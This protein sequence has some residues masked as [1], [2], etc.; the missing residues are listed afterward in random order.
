MRRATNE[1]ERSRSG[2]AR[3][4]DSITSEELSDSMQVPSYP[5][6][7]G[8]RALWSLYKM[9][10]ESVAYNLSAAAAV[11]SDTNVD[12]LRRAF[13]QLAQRHPMLRTLFIAPTAAPDSEPR[14]RILPTAEVDF[15]CEDA[16][17]LSQAQLNERLA[18]AIYHPFDLEHRPGWRVL[19]LQ[20]APQGGDAAAS[21]S[22]HEHL[23]LLVI[24]HVLGD[25]WSIAVI[26]SEVGALYR[27]EAMGI[28]ADLKPLHTSYTDHICKE[29]EMLR[30]PQADA[31][32]EYWRTHLS[33]DLPPIDLPTDRPRPS[34]PT[35]RG[36]AQSIKIGYDLAARLRQLAETGHVALY[37]V[38]LTAFQTLLHRYTG[39]NDVLVGFPKAGRTHAFARVV[40]YFVNPVVTRAD[41]SENPR[42]GELLHANQRAIEDGAAHDWYPFS[43]L[44]QRLRPSREFG[45][46]PIFQAMFSWQKTTALLP[47]EQAGSLVRE[48]GDDAVDLGGL[49][50]RPVPLAHH[51]APVD[52]T[53][54]AIED[55]HGLVA[56]LEYSTDLFDA[57]TI[58]RMAQ[59]FCLLLEGIA[60]DPERGVS[61][62]PIMPEYERQKLVEEWNATA[63]P[64]PTDAC[65]HEL[66]EGQAERTPDTL[67]LIAGEERLT[68]RALNERANQLAHYLRQLG[69]VPDTP[70]GLFCPRSAPA[71]IGVLAVL[72][73]GGA[74][75]PLDPT[76]PDERLA[77]MLRDA[78]VPLLLTQ[79]AMRARLARIHE[80][81]VGG[82]ALS[83]REGM[84]V[85]CLDPDTDPDRGT[86]RG[87]D[88]SDNT[89]ARRISQQ[90]TCNPP[91]VTSPD[92]LA[93]IIYTSGS[94]GQPNGVALAH[95]GVVSLLTDFQRRQSLLPGDGCSWWTS[96]S[97][98]V[99]VYEIF[100]SWLTG[101]T[102]HVI[103]E[104]IRLD[105]PR[106][107]AWL[108]TYQIRSAY[109]PPFLLAEFAR[110]L[111]AHPGASALRRLLVGVEPI[112]EHLLVN[113][114]AQ[115]PDLCLLNG[116]GPSETTIC[117]TLYQV[118]A[119]AP[120]GAIAHQQTPIGGPAANTQIYLLDRHMQP[121]PQGVVGEVYIGGVGLARGY[122]RRPEL[123]A[124]RFLPHPFN[125]ESG[126]RLY[127]TGDLARLLPDGNLEFVGR[128][129]TQVKLRGYRIELGEIEAALAQH[130]NVKQ[131]AVALRQELS[132]NK[133]LVAYLAPIHDPP[134]SPTELRNFLVKSLPHAVMPSAFVVL[135]AFPLTPSGK[136]DRRALP[137]PPAPRRSHPLLEPQPHQESK[138]EAPRTNA[139]RTLVAIWQQV[140]DVAQ[141]G[142]HDNF[143]ELGGDSILGI[144]IIARAADAGLHVTPQQLFE[145]P[146][147]AELAALAEAHTP[148]TKRIQP[149]QG[150]LEGDVPLTPIQ[151]WFFERDHPNPHHWNQALMFVTHQPLEPAALRAAVAAIIEHHDALRLRYTRTLATWS[152]TYTSPSEDDLCAVIDLSSVPESR[153]TAAIEEH[154]AAL[155]RGLNLSTGP[156]LRVAYF[157]LGAS[158][159]G[160]L[161][162]I[163]H[164]LTIDGVSWRILI[165]DFQRAYGQLRLGQP[166]R[167]PPKTTSYRDWAQRLTAF[168]QSSDI[169]DEA[170]FWLNAAGPGLPG[171]P[172]NR[173]SATGA[174][175][176]MNTEASARHVS[177]C[178]SQKETQA[179]LQR[180]PI[181]YGAAI[182]D[183]LL[184]ALALAF[185]R[186]TGVPALWIDLEGHGREDIFDGIDL[187]RTVGW[188]TTLYPVRLEV[189][190]DADHGQAVQMIKEQ[191]RRIPYHGLAYGLLRYLCTDVALRQQ[192]T[193]IPPPQISF[194]YLGQI[195]Q[196]TGDVLID[197]PA[198]ESPGPLRSPD[199]LRSH[200]LEIDAAITQGKLRLDWTY[201]AHAH[202]RHTI[203]QVAANFMEGMRALIARCD[204]REATRTST[205]AFAGDT[206]SAFSSAIA[207]HQDERDALL[208]AVAG[209]SREDITQ[210]DQVLSLFEDVA[211]EIGELDDIADIYP[212]SPMQQGMI[213]HTML[214]PASGIYLEQIAGDIQGALNVPA[215][216]R[217]WQRV[218]ERHSV[219]RTAI[220]GKRLDRMLQVV[221]KDAR[222]PLELLDWRTLA[223]A[224]QDTRLRALLASDRH[225][226]FDL[227]KAPLMRLF[228]VRTADDMHRFVLTYHHVVLD[229]WSL[230]LLFKEIFAHYEAIT[231]HEELTL[232]SARP[233]R[234]YIAWLQ[235]QDT[236]AAEAFW[237]NALAGCAATSVP[238]LRPLLPLGRRSSS[239]AV[240]S[241]PAEHAMSLPA[242]ATAALQAIAR[243]HHLTLNTIVQ[244]ALALLLSRYAQQ[245]E[246]L[247]GVTVAGRSPGLA[248]IDRMIGLFIN[249]LPLRVVVDPHADLIEWLQ[250]LQQQAIK[251]QQYDYSSLV[252]VQEWSG[253]PRGT[254]LFETILVF[255]N[256]PIEAVLGEQSGSL[257]IRD[258]RAIEHVNYPLAVVAIPGEQLQFK[259]V[260]DA[261]R[262]EPDFINR[263]LRGLCQVLEDMATD[264]GQRL[265]AVSIGNMEFHGQSESQVTLG[266]YRIELGEVEAALAQ[267]PNV[268]QVAVVARHE[269]PS[270]RGTPSGG[271]QSLVAY[272]I[273]FGDPPSV[274]ELRSFLRDRLP[275]PMIPGSFVML[276]VFPLLPSGQVDRPTLMARAEAELEPERACAPVQNSLE[277][278]LAEVW[279]D[280]LDLERVGIHDDF[281]ELGGN[282]LLGAV[283]INRLQDA[284]HEDV[285]LTA[286]FDRP[287]IAELARYL[288][289]HHREGVAHLLG[290][291]SPIRSDGRAS[292]IRAAVND[293]P[294]ARSPALVAIQPHGTRPPL[295][296]IHPAGGI[297]FPYYTLVPYLGKD[298][299]LYGIQDPDLYNKRSTVNS[300]EEMAAQYVMVLRTVQ[301]EGPYYLMGWSVGGLVAYEMARQLTRHG[302][303]I[304]T[305]II[306]DTAA[307]TPLKRAAQGRSLRGQMRRIGPQVQELRTMIRKIRTWGSTVKPILSYV[308]SGLYLLAASRR[309][310]HTRLDRKPTALDLLRWAGI[311]TWRARLL[312][313]AAVAHAVSRETSLLLVEMPAVQRI[314]EL[315]RKHRQLAQRYSA[316]PYRGR[317]TLIR[318]VPA[319]PDDPQ[320]Q[321]LMMGW[322]QLAEGE[323]EIHTIRTNHVALLVKPYVEALAHELR[324][325]LDRTRNSLTKEADI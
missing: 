149:E 26:M 239:I 255:E 199:A 188:F 269:Y 229:G 295:F 19:V 93:Y 21:G 71:L 300:I 212:F 320:P 216:E 150:I 315:V 54:A 266:G 139:E 88:D 100:S 185:R 92:H 256:Y 4:M 220:I 226:G 87:T 214:A 69:V 277:R 307:P 169:R 138:F 48:Q 259:V 230:A 187:S 91:H 304:A 232:P 163:S 12:A 250:Q 155:Q 2:R 317:I 35:G 284:L 152:Q 233:Y 211:V 286:I 98:D 79:R 189:S 306:L 128:R 89:D 243:R 70:I 78:N 191:L 193:A 77:L 245:D 313:D 143:F 43:Q 141:V 305:L 16:S 67:A 264:P 181:T 292:T 162:F 58:D 53:M 194:N 136:V 299:P 94:T 238:P 303:A 241:Q 197:Y 182:N 121:V 171:L 324:I 157:I 321:D 242:Q 202:K 96:L 184:T 210:A 3:T 318:A 225:R 44:V 40:G 285:P 59:S 107:L 25:L 190:P 301:S 10:P 252:Q 221:Y 173:R 81:S 113:I 106:L 24:H 219:L 164:H 65:L 72:K 49:V 151:H 289:D 180:V 144:Q 280:L 302:Q 170:A 7:V 209:P 227:T 235:A 322:Q 28:P 283:L 228:I 271:Q 261:E 97:F 265:A 20:H 161:L 32:W 18:S 279:Q 75:V 34:L 103:P 309:R 84:R 183:V 29:V 168:A 47:R 132:G 112:A 234:E 17:A 39:Q 323:V 61:D 99:S 9:A 240:P 312:K 308:H 262:F 236:A 172:V 117:S 201:S 110:W 90:P 56:M 83:D 297:V 5:L 147:V 55:S 281:F 195:H 57:A 272:W 116:Y 156:L 247:F 274:G 198:P 119:T 41:F 102:L 46:S 275:K 148:A 165:E 287:T 200:L 237:R 257:L 13:E 73:A 296:C 15:R 154:A 126:A 208:T 311:D 294:A 217:A 33:G 273:A 186:W 60:S 325:C 258:V 206:H 205:R 204:A 174:L 267:H 248:G 109:L 114:C 125:A 111:D 63:A 263:L 310:M 11:P 123:T 85:V 290:E 253:I 82:G 203:E 291:Q 62:L 115:L 213:F 129:D 124:S 179:L 30:G 23:V 282:S 270:D 244:G 80:V 293:E 268:K 178:L 222:V 14:Q 223:T 104:S 142:L 160:R 68:Y 31:S 158:H 120:R 42:F 153:Q 50:I 278:H 36:A 134:P 6:S 215:F 166:V 105:A 37:T 251:A 118:T 52:L 246:V 231:R 122:W 224:E 207:G 260:F 130:P 74:Y 276:D 146:S 101:G 314:L 108:H 176:T 38:L 66:I 249:T 137:E 177:V 316:A 218:L 1:Y 133:H 64:Y 8:Q 254:P 298:Q 145:A 192:I 135:D 51:V 159:P 127:R 27:E 175:E 131:A 319:G 76:Y 196:L 45:R 167:L 86:D 288:E 22:H 140:L 95:R